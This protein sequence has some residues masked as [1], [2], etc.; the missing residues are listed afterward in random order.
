MRNRSKP[1]MGRMFWGIVAIVLS[2]C[3]CTAYAVIIELPLDSAG[4][5]GGPGASYFEEYFDLGVHFSEIS[6]VSIV[7]SGSIKGSVITNDLSNGE[8]EVVDTHC[9][10]WLGDLDATAE[11][12]AGQSTY[13]DPEQFEVTTKFTLRVN[14]TWNNLLDGKGRLL[15]EENGYIFLPWVGGGGY[16]E[17]GE[18]SLEN[19][20][21]VF[22]GTVV[23]EPAS[24]LLLLAGVPVMKKRKT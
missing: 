13:P 16:L 8:P 22:E 19:A 3:N 24:L 18:I 12:A 5:Y 11:V 6:T 15:I 4:V 10:A 23:P 9:I 20:T 2:S 14:H 21:L 1:L 7:W 17:Y